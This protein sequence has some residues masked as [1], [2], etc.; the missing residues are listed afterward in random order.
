MNVIRGFV[1]GHDAIGLEYKMLEK[2]EKIAY[3]S[4]ELLDVQLKNRL[5]YL[6]QCVG[7][8]KE[9]KH[10]RFYDISSM[11]K[12][13]ALKSICE[14]GEF[15]VVIVDQLVDFIDNLN[16]PAT[17]KTLFETLSKL[18]KENNLAMICVIH[19]NEDSKSSSKARGHVGSLFEQKAMMSIA[20][21]KSN[22]K[23]VISS[24]KASES[25]QFTFTAIFDETTTM[26]KSVKELVLQSDVFEGVQF[27]IAK[28]YL[29]DHL[30]KKLKIIKKDI[31]KDLDKYAERYKLIATTKGNRVL[32]DKA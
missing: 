31:E 21:N 19:Q 10:I 14:M 1:T 23:F 20:I 4:T 22:A 13:S 16:D 12:M 8:E 7:E 15:R 2:T 29:I 28:T 18:C 24:T 5:Y 9:E 30:N 11:E 17:S 32:Y 3:C 25:E 26:L 27:P 6:S